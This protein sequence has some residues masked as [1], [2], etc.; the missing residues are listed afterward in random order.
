MH[1]LPA[2]RLLL[3]SWQSL[4]FFGLVFWM[5]VTESV[6]GVIVGFPDPEAEQRR[7]EF[8]GH[9]RFRHELL[10]HGIQADL[11]PEPLK[12]PN[13]KEFNVIIYG[14]FTEDP[15]IKTIDAETR[16][17]AAA[18]RQAL[19]QFVNSGGGLIVLPA[20]R[21]YPGQAIDEYYT[22]VL[23]GFGIK[24]L[25]EGIW[26]PS[27]QFKDK[28]TLAFA[29]LSYFLTTQIKPHPVTQG[30]QRLALPQTYQ[31]APAIAALSYSTDW[32]VLVSGESTAQSYKRNAEYY[33][34]LKQ[35]GTYKA[36]PPIA[37]VRQFGK[38]RVFC[39]PLPSAHISLNFGN[40]SWPHTTETVGDADSKLPSFSHQLVINAIGWVSE[41]SQKLPGFGTRKIP[42]RFPSVH[43][44]EKVQLPPPPAKAAKEPIAL[45]RG[46]LGAHSS[47]SDGQGSVE[48]YA[49]AAAEAKLQFVI[50]AES[51]EHLTAEKWR[52]LVETCQQLSQ[53]GPV[54][55]V[56][57]YEYSDVNGVR[58]AIWGKQVVYP[59]R[60]FF[61]QDG[62]RILRD[63]NLTYAS[64]LAGR[65]LLDYD[66]LPGDPANMWWF[67]S[68]PIWVYDQ[69]KLVADNLKQYLLARDNLYMVTAA[70]FTR[71]K[72]PREVTAAARRCTWN[73]DPSRHPRLSAAVDTSASQW[74]SWTSASQGG[75]KGPRLAWAELVWRA[76]NFYRTSGTQRVRGTFRAS[77]AAGLQEVRLHDG[78][79]GIV[80]RFLCGGAKEFNRTIELVHDRQHELVLEAVDRQG[81]RAIC[82]AH[83]L[84]SLSQGF[85]RCSDNN[86]LLGTT[87]AGAFPDRHDFPRFATFEDSDL[88][89]LVG[90]DSGTGNMNKPGAIPTIFSVQTAAGQQGPQ[91]LKPVPD[92]AGR[93]IVQTP[94]RFPFSSYEINVVEASS[95]KYV[96]ELTN[97]S[98]A[99]G[100]FMPVGDALPY[101]TLDRRAYLLRS[102][103]DY[104][105]KSNA[106]RPHEAAANYQGDIFVHEGTLR[107]RQDVTLKGQVPILL[108]RVIYKGGS[109]Y[110]QADR[111]LIEDAERGEVMLHYG[112]QD[113]IHQAGTLR[114]GGWLT[115]QFTDGGALAAVPAIDG[116][117]YEINTF[118]TGPKS[119]TW[120]YFFGLGRD[121]QKV[122]KGEEMRYR[123]LAVSISGRTPKDDHLLKSVG[124]S[125]ILD[126]K[127]ISPKDVEVGQLLNPEVI[128]TGRANNH[129]FV[130]KFQPASLMIN[131]PLRIEGIEDN[132]CAAVYVL[133]G[134]PWEKRFRFVGVFENAALFQQNTDQ[135]PTLWV[136]N[137]FYAENAKL[138]MTLVAEGLRPGERPFL[139]VH[140]P[141]DSAVTTIV[142]SPQ[143]TPHYGGFSK[144]V[145]VPAGDSIILRLP[146]R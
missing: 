33:L 91:Y 23:E 30:V 8:V 143:H 90:F 98:P 114:K 84:F 93:R 15:K 75:E 34:D 124:R 92:D 127:G 115:G 54:L 106:R 132:G 10:Q 37:A 65:M 18:E 51:L 140:N 61:A 31:A 29:P 82:S 146:D 64:N 21:R 136:G 9:D 109:E 76:G 99:Q 5:G 4:V 47:F 110:G 27:H 133:N 42:E 12:W 100:P 103:M 129:E 126:P 19:E 101:A 125:F 26:D 41:P 81:Q 68:V 20:L 86:N 25:P 117:R 142:R 72:S 59:R 1:A 96:K 73:V 62:K 121:G 83:R 39:Y 118:S 63:G 128:T 85:Y 3:R 6:A 32:T 22:L 139:E 123:Y 104:F 80:R 74:N 48:D 88:I 95:Q 11:C 28:G 135:G 49:K 134:N 45:Q 102:R 55:L 137:P 89:T 87:P 107:F 77:S 71:I 38:G 141:T 46:I 52:K 122:R 78:T 79:H 50:F 44:D 144:R 69:D 94:M 24:V 70:C 56:P 35:P 120:N 40:P 2:V 67:Y 108:E 58:W 113:K 97:D 13:L 17:R 116:M 53:K 57:G 131:R 130:A 111:V 105:L 36:A 60:E 14:G 16:K 145:M 112:P 43:W 119:L 7:A 138:R 66:K